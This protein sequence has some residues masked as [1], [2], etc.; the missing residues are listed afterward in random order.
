M[1]CI[2]G[3]EQ[4]FEEGS[5]GDVYNALSPELGKS[6]IRLEMIILSE[7]ALDHL[8]SLQRVKVEVSPRLRDKSKC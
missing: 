2:G 6:T 4:G 8:G 3:S 5:R 1:S 7:K